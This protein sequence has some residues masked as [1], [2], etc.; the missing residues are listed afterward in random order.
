M[1]N[2]NLASI[3][4]ETIRSA[5]PML[6]ILDAGVAFYDPD[7]SLHLDYAER[8]HGE[9]SPFDQLTLEAGS[10]AFQAAERGEI[11]HVHDFQ[12]NAPNSPV[13]DFGSIDAAMAAPLIVEGETVG[14]FVVTAANR[15]ALANQHRPVMALLTDRLG[16]QLTSQV[17]GL[18]QHHIQQ[19]Y[20]ALR[21]SNRLLI[22]SAQTDHELYSQTCHICVDNADFAVAWIAQP[23]ESGWFQTRA[24]AGP[25]RGLIDD[26]PVTTD[27]SKPEGSGS[28]GEA[29]RTGHPVYLQAPRD[30]KQYEN[31]H[32]AYDRHDI[33]GVAAVPLRRHDRIEAILLVGAYEANYFGEQEKRVFETIA[34]DLSEALELLDERVYTRIASAAVDNSPNGIMVADPTTQRVL[35]SNRAMSDLSGLEPDQIIGRTGLFFRSEDPT[36]EELPEF[37]SSLA[38]DGQW[39]GLIW[40]SHDT[41]GWT[42]HVAVQSITGPDNKPRLLAIYGPPPEAATP[43]LRDDLT[44]LP[45]ASSFH[46]SLI[47]R[48]DTASTEA[49]VLIR[50]DIRDLDSINKIYGES[51]GDRLLIELAGRLRRSLPS[52]ALVARLE[53]DNFAILTHSVRRDT[54]ARAAQRLLRRVESSI[55]HPFIIDNNELPVQVATGVAFYPADAEDAA[56]LLSQAETALDRT[57]SPNQDSR[58]LTEDDARDIQGRLT[59]ASNLKR[60]IHQGEAIEPWY[61]PEIH[62]HSGALIGAEALA[63]WHNKDQDLVSPGEFL[64]LAHALGMTTR[65]NQSVLDGVLRNMARWL[66][67]AT[68]PVPVAVNLSADQLADDELPDNLMAALNAYKLPPSLLQV[69]V[70]ERDLITH[71]SGPEDVIQKL[72]DYG[73]EVSLDDFGTGYAALSILRDLTL[74]RLKLDKSLIAGLG[75]DERSIKIARLAINFAHELDM[76][77]IAEG[78]ETQEKADILK[79]LGCDYAQGFLFARPMPA[80]EFETQWL[81]GQRLS[82]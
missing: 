67:S 70:T 26:M 14:A 29:W 6:D 53:D 18:R 73:I 45:N 34:T 46:K 11:I 76:H 66:E 63:R 71:A 12:H 75:D 50:I 59:T 80:S 69:E 78:I 52:D 51:G 15:E 17:L 20:D 65:L 49:L 42:A 32:S 47:H 19:L 16:A 41:R 44:G 64:P 24:N 61:Q 39:Q 77:V 1:T 7:G 81:R 13:R 36:G 33:R 28:V 9:S 57:Q 82:A 5:F 2:E 8:R 58:I 4:L 22:G 55:D 79:G 74:K 68:H 54:V 62:L 40:G 3:C 27:G 35:Y 48:I 23:D 31:W 10:V 60:A 25:G 38:E 21:E 30:R 43:D 37:E 56:G 72:R